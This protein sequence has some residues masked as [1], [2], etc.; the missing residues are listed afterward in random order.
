MLPL[1]YP[2]RWQ[3]AGIL[4]L[5]VTLTA[6]LM[7]AV[8]FWDDRVAALRWFENTDKWLHGIAFLVLSFWFAGLYA[9]R[10][11]WRVAV[12]LLLFGVAIEVLQR[13]I[14]YRTADLTD[15]AADAAGI[16]VGLSLGV[17]GA[18]GWCLRVEKRWLKTGNDAGV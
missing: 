9:V 6:A 8:W 1:R 17:A 7:P 4:L 14:S 2:L 5:I 13:M 10:S 11:L 15:I 18:A 12:G 16:I 3:V